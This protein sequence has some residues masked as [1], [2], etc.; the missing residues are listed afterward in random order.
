VPLTMPAIMRDGGRDGAGDQASADLALE[1]SLSSR[2]G[3]S[4]YPK[5]SGRIIRVF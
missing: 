2:G 4:G 3:R 5:I 1:I